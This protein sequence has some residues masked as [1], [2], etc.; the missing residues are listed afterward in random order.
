MS[1]SKAC[2]AE[3]HFLLNSQNKESQAEKRASPKARPKPSVLVS[4]QSRSPLP[5]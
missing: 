5:F 4:V 2:L 1:S 3:T